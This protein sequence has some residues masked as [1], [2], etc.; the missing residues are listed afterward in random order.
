MNA[1]AVTDRAPKVTTCPFC[2]HNGAHAPATLTP[3]G[4][5]RYCSSCPECETEL[6]Q[7]ADASHAAPPRLAA[8]PGNAVA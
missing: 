5:V 3:S 1:T 2:G 6:E 7:M 8:A 4:G